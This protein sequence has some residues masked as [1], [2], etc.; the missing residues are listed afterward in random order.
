MEPIKVNMAVALGDFG[1][2]VDIGKL[3][4]EWTWMLC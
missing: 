1:H 3:A 2:G 4:P